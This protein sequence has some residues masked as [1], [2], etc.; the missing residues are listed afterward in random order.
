[1]EDALIRAAAIEVG[2]PCGVRLFALPRNHTASDR[3]S[4]IHVTVT[5]VG[6]DVPAIYLSFVMWSFGY[7]RATNGYEGRQSWMQWRRSVAINQTS[8][9]SLLFSRYLVHI[10]NPDPRH[11]ANAGGGLQQR[12]SVVPVRNLSRLNQ[13]IYMDCHSLMCDTQFM[14]MSLFCWFPS[15]AWLCALR[16]DDSAAGAAS[17]PTAALAS[18][19]QAPPRFYCYRRHCHICLTTGDWTN[20][21]KNNFVSSPVV[22]SH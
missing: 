9:S 10:I 18:S 2:Q 4:C 20:G 8:R 14:S 13:V 7:S 17:W 16:D 15:S 11:S 19:S 21:R 22:P 6:C 5:A 12:L 1:M 3:V